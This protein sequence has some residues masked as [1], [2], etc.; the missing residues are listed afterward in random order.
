MA[1]VPMSHPIVV[2]TTMD[3]LR[4][5]GKITGIGPDP[6]GGGAA[7]IQMKVISFQDTDSSV[8]STE[9]TTFIGFFCPSFRPAEIGLGDRVWVHL[10]LLASWSSVSIAIAREKRLKAISPDPDNYSYSAAGEIVSDKSG[11]RY[12]HIGFPVSLHVGRHP[13]HL[14]KPGQFLKEGNFIEISKANL[15]GDV[16]L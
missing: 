10:W 5:N 8:K 7:T 14:G 11:G 2:G 12:L 1:R 16:E 9:G 15:F 4:V 6:A 13:T 3:Y